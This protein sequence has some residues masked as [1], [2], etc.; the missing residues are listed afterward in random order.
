MKRATIDW[1]AA[2]AV[3]T[4]IAS[5]TTAII[6]GLALGTYRQSILL[7]Q[8]LS[9]CAA[10]Y[11]VG[12]HMETRITSAVHLRTR[13]EAALVRI[14]DD[15][16][17][18]IGEAM[19]RLQMVSS[20]ELQDLSRLYVQRLNAAIRAAETAEFDPTEAQRTLS[21]ALDVRTRLFVHC[22]APT[23]IDSPWLVSLFPVPE[24]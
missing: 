7:E 2:S 9:S 17:R 22:R 15:Q 13:G 24:D 19:L 20:R 1:T 11:D 16:T 3:V 14:A 12:T 5:V 21:E 6:A 4:A 10:L 23:G 8:R 18:R